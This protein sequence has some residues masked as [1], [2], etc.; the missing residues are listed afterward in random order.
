[1]RKR[2][3]IT[4]GAVGLGSAIASL[5][6][7]KGY[8]IAITYL[9]HEKEALELKR[10]LES[11]YDVLVDIYTLDL[12]NE[13]ELIDFVSSVGE[14]DVLVNNA[15][16]N[17][18]FDIFEKTSKDF[19]RAYK[20]NAVGP[21]LLAKGFYGVLKKRKGNIVNIAST[22]GIDTMYAESIDYDASKAALI[23][24]TKNMALAFAPDI[25]VNAVAP[26]WIDTDKTSD[27]EPKF[28]SEEES[29]I[30]LRRFAREEEV[31]SVVYFVASEEASFIDGNIIR[32]DGGVKYED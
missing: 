1:M 5:F 31:A 4:G 19:L 26:G 23:N 3:L 11:K 20:I 28:R 24:M 2:V 15:A 17:D 22:N 8:D 6:A 16:F 30:L 32:V 12:E 25:R 21:F 27:M 14:I 10:S 18:D 7:K 29:K 13:E 9:T